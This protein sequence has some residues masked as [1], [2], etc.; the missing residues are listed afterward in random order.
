MIWSASDSEGL[1]GA[2]FFERRLVVFFLV[3]FFFELGFFLLARFFFD[4]LGF[5]DVSA[6]A[7]AIALR[8]SAAAKL[9]EVEAAQPR[10]TAG[11]P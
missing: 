6:M 9:V 3:L 2:F 5:F 4:V 10:T 11:G 1:L 8:T 7:M